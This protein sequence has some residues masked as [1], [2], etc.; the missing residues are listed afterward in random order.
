MDV[1]HYDSECN[2]MVFCNCGSQFTSATCSD[3]PQE[4]LQRISFY[5]CLEIYSGGGAHVKLMTKPGTATIARL[6]RTSDRYRMDIILAEFLEF[7]SKKDGGND[8]RMAPCIFQA[9]L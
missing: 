5:P 1:R 2:V 4:N 7:A 9:A 3:D 6:N 8:R